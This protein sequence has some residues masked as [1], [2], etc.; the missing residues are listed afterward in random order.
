MLL[1]LVS[2]DWK[3]P[4]IQ[5][6]AEVWLSRYPDLVGVCLNLNKAKGNVIFGKETRLV[7]GKSY[8]REVFAGLELHLSSDTFFQV[9]TETAEQ[10][11]EV[12]VKELQLQGTETLLDAYCGVGTFTLP[13]SRLVAEVIGIEIQESSLER[14][15]YNARLNGL[16]NVT[17]YQGKVEE[18]LPTLE[19]TPDVILVDPPRKGCDPQVI[20]TLRLLRSA[21]LV[22][23]S[24]Q[25]PTLARDLKLLTQDNV[26]KITRVQSADFFPQTSHVESLVFLQASQ[27]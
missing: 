17:F 5:E 14:A 22:Y 13:L 12:I 4:H 15:Y 1:T 23:I 3:L 8:I 20:E 19:I 6:Q 25:P 2:T 9:N 27:A 11:L 18:V 24:C 26:Y 10:V 16:N 7:M 21:H